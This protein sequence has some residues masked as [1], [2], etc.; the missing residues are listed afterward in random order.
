ERREL[1]DVEG[2]SPVDLL[3]GE[4]LETEQA[5]VESFAFGRVLFLK[6]RDVLARRVVA[7]TFF[8]DVPD[9]VKYR[10]ERRVLDD[11]EL[12]VRDRRRPLVVEDGRMHLA[13]PATERLLGQ[14]AGVARPERDDHLD[15]ANV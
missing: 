10:F 7:V 8:E 3:L 2:L 12:L 1:V 9:L 5:D 15:V 11:V 6:D 14:R 4:P 13:E